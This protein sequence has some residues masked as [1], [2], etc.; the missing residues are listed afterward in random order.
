MGRVTGAPSAA[1]PLRSQATQTPHHALWCTRVIVFPPPR[2]PSANP[3]YKL[4][5]CAESP[6]S[7]R[8][9]TVCSEV[10][11]PAMGRFVELET[12]IISATCVRPR[13]S[14]LVSRPRRYGHR[15]AAFDSSQR[16]NSKR[17]ESCRVLVTRAL[18]RSRIRGLDRRRAKKSTSSA[19]A[20]QGP[21]RSERTPPLA[22]ATL[23]ARPP[24]RAGKTAC[25]AADGCG[26]DP[27]HSRRRPR[28]SR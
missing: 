19:R 11:L 24:A 6:D 22:A 7:G 16:S 18:W 17:I 26:F 13:R 21:T 5:R 15:P 1:Q 28:C 27:M 12:T 23:Q 3:Y 20:A 8:I 14:D 10:P 25:A 2:I 9:G 4:D